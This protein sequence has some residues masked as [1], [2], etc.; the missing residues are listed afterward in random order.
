[1]NLRIMFEEYVMTE[2]RDILKIIP[3]AALGLTAFSLGADALVPI[4]AGKQSAS[5]Q[6]TFDPRKQRRIPDIPG[7]THTGQHINFYEDLVKDKVCLIHFMSIRAEES[8]SVTQRLAAVASR[9]GEKLG[10]EV[11]MISVTRD[12][13]NDTPGQLAAFA[14]QRANFKGWTFVNLAAQGTSAMTNRIYH[15]HGHEPVTTER[16][17]PAVDIVFY[18][19]GA[20][21]LWSSFPVDIDPDDAVRR[22]GWVL[23]GKSPDGSLNKAGP[24]RPAH[25]GL[26][27]DN[28]IA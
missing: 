18:G 20:V 9:L 10:R 12:P 4:P 11:F 5:T 27:S 6:N 15:S 28:R 17:N 3:A 1:M 19:N 16:K 2:R 26:E 8:Y 24:R 25:Q 22:V 7:V 21:G 14:A 13:L 23:P